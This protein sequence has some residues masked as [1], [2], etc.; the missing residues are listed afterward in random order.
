MLR[1]LLADVLRLDRSQVDSVTALRNAVG[2]VTPLAAGAA[3]GHL[4]VGLTVAIGALNVAFSDRPGAYQVRLRRMLLAG[5]CAALSVFVGAAT[6]A[7]AAPAIAVATLWAF[8]GGF[9]VAL[10]PVATQIG[11]TDVVLLLVFAAHPLPPSLAA[12]Q[13]GLILAGG[14]IQAVLAVLAWPVRRFGPQRD[15]LA[16]AFRQ[17]AEV[18][19]T[20][21]APASPPA[22]GAMTQARAAVAAS[23]DNSAPSEALR[24]LL[25]AAERVRLELIA[26]GDA[27]SR[28]R[29]RGDTLIAA[30]IDAVRDT[31]GAIS[32]SL[33]DS[34]SGER[35]IAGASGSTQHM[36]RALEDLRAVITTPLGHREAPEGVA[37]LAHGEVLGGQLRA[38]IEALGESGGSDT[39]RDREEA[40]RPH[41]LRLREPAAI[42]RA[43]L[44]LRSTA[45]RH[46]VRLA[47]C[48]LLADAV[49]RGLGLP[50]TYWL[51]LT[52]AIVLKPDFGSTFSRSVG[53]V[54]GTVAGLVLATALVFTLFGALPARVVLVGLLV[55]AIRS[56]G[57]ANYSVLVVG[58]TALVVILTSF[59]GAR[60][61]ATIIERGAY[62]LAGGLLALAAYTSW[63]TWE[64][65]QTGAVLADLLDAYRR[66]FAAVLQGYLMPGQQDGSVDAARDASRLARTDAEASVDRLRAEPQ[67]SSKELDSATG[68]LA[69]SHRFVHSTLALEAG[70]HHGRPSPAAAVL[71]PF[72]T[73]VDTALQQLARRLRARSASTGTLPDLRADQRALVEW[74]RGETAR[75]MAPE[76]RI[77][78][79]IVVAEADRI[80]SSVNTMATVLSDLEDL[81][82][83]AP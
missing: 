78:L 59:A 20:P 11:L 36:T 68:L 58:I 31:A 3:T 4:L 44:T 54:V 62:T 69:A 18:G 23:G 16:S 77:R 39:Q 60:P 35:S 14:A 15:A 72:A 9:L 10:G 61:E 82:P 53:R 38:A 46:A 13:A 5:V 7:Y 48:L 43:N 73:H 64:R 70:M 63:P 71:R 25:D 33:A 49:G 50:R 75:A 17:I 24:T 76:E 19:R 32:T 28:C 81:E 45:C 22:G 52:V 74:S 41:L 67:R 47:G 12:D 80:T 29:Q 37:V 2:V 56:L 55:F 66:Y 65:T 26:L 34:L 8:G 83:G 40:R 79:A 57:R 21:S 27:S 42:L 51:P 6:G 1:P 30:R